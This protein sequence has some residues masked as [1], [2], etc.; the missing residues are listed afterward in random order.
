MQSRNKDDFIH[1]I[2]GTGERPRESFTKKNLSVDGEKSPF[3][4]G[5]PP[6][7]ISKGNAI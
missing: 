2:K 6:F 5:F 7:I 4:K 3:S 1:S